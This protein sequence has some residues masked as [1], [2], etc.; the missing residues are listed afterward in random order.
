M[1]GDPFRFQKTHQMGGGGGIDL[2]LARNATPLLGIECGGV[3]LVD[4]QDHIGIVGG[5]ELLGLALVEQ[6]T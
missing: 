4:V 1:G 2:P 6:A 3:I 5:E